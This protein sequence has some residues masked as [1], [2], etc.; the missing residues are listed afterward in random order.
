MEIV[1]WI[2]SE[3]GDIVKQVNGVLDR[4]GIRLLTWLIPIVVLAF[5]Y[6]VIVPTWRILALSLPWSLSRSLTDLVRL[7]WMGIGRER[8]YQAARLRVEWELL[9]PRPEPTP[10]HL[11]LPRKGETPSAA[12]AR[13]N[14]ERRRFR[15]ELATWK[16]RLK[17]H[18]AS[19]TRSG[20]ELV[21]IEVEDCSQI[22]ARGAQI[23]NYF[24]V[25]ATDR[26]TQR[27]KPDQFISL[28]RVK[29]G[30]VAPLHLVAGLLAECEEDWAPVIQDYGR[31]VA[32][33]MPPIANA[34]G[35]QPFAG[36]VAQ[37]KFQRLQTFLFDCWL[38]WGPSIPHLHLRRMVERP[39]AAIRLR[40]REQFA[41]A[42]RPDWP[43]EKVRSSCRRA[44]Q[45]PV[46]FQGA[47]SPACPAGDRAQR[48]SSMAQQALCAP[49]QALRCR[50]RGLPL[51]FG[52]RATRKSSGATTRPIC[53]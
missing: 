5:A 37:L 43:L 49:K 2:G 12:K 45:S 47:V 22:Y 1:N 19:R 48:T 34:H 36:R 9:R 26:S 4:P 6:R 41:R 30:F 29:R 33:P 53:G 32:H 52:S 16:E 35:T 10:R 15:D 40:R 42:A 27:S 7:G 14:E 20:D 18:L 39:H 21:T 24:G 31:Q 23:R 11:A 25:L 38:L 44:T 13:F 17:E 46:A 51:E 3:I 8:W 28:V 50:S